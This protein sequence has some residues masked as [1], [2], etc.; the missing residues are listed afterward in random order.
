MA[1]DQAERPAGAG[2]LSRRRFLAATGAAAGISLLG[3]KPA[4]LSPALPSVTGRS[5]AGAE[6]LVL[7]SSQDG[8]VPHAGCP[9]AHCEAARR[10]PELGRR[11]P[12]LG[13]LD[14]AERK[15][16]MID[17]GPDFP[18][19]LDDLPSE[20]RDGRNPL[21]G[22][23]L[24]HAHIGHYAGLVHLGR[25]VLGTLK[26]P[27]WCSERMAAFLRDN[28]P[29]SQL[30]GLGNIE[31]NV[32]E[33]RRKFK[34]TDNL[35]IEPI[36][37]PHRAEY[38]DTHFFVVEGPKHR[39]LYLTDIDRWEGLE[40]PIEALVAGVDIA[41]LDGTF[42]SAEE[43][44]GRDMSKIPHPP[45]VETAARLADIAAAGRTRIVFTHL[46]HSNLL[47][48]ADGEKLRALRDKGFDIAHDGQSFEL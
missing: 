34:L 17:A 7:G 14:H 25:E 15:A 36:A 12:G 21:A 24:S 39:L 44:P 11:S 31:L 47:L 10:N 38:T 32:F 20:W 30:V 33:P 29:W 4:Y 18:R 2:K 5:A 8:G 35:V 6:A 46:N 3:M 13:L 9:C 45:V 42:Y 48:D 23:V 28:G 37:V 26:V 16:F 22:V 40:P 43:L 1:D 41:L 19:Q 27:V